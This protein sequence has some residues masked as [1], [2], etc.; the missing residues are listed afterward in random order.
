MVHSET[1]NDL[2]PWSDADLRSTTEENAGLGVDARVP[3]NI[4]FRS[5]VAK[6]VRRRSSTQDA[7]T[8]VNLPA[9]FLLQ[10]SPPDATSGMQLTRVPMLD[11]GRHELN[12]KIWFL[13]AGP[14]SGHFIP[15][16]DESDD[17][18]FRFVTDTL[19][20]GDIPTIVF[21]PRLDNPC[22]RYY[23]S[24]LNDLAN[25][26][27]LFL[28][29]TQVTFDSVSAVVER[30]YSKKMKTPDAQPTA[31]KLWKDQRKWWPRQDAEYRVQMYLEVALNT[32]FPTCVIRSEQSTPEGRL[33]IEILEHQ[34]N[35]HSVVTQHGVLELKV[36]RSFSASGSDVPQQFTRRLIKEGVEQ[37]AAYRSS[38]GA[39]WSALVC[40]D[41]RK[42]DGGDSSC[43]KHVRTLA[44]KLNVYLRRWFMYATSRQ[45]RSAMVA[46]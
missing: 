2:G 46:K 30:T 44:E 10:P 35:D 45:L 4:R 19:G 18:L 3:T 8:D 7:R 39:K 38:K 12:G 15:F 29:G 24:G 1:R 42:H 40:F 41:M 36:L 23:S 17:Q 5:N 26:E 28:L 31:G 14:G 37:A 6:L 9:I 32:G 20:L 27:D 34:A 21:E 43:F 22:L 33:D 13:G 16:G 11:N 25:Y